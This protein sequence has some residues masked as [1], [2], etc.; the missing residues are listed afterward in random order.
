[1]HELSLVVDMLDQLSQM[2]KQHQLASISD[3]HV[4]VGEIS[5]VDAG[6]LRSTFD[7]H[8]PGTL[9]ADLRLHLNVIPWQVRCLDCGL[10]QVVRDWENQCQHCQSANTETI[11][12]KEFIIKRIEGETHV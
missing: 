7:L 1:M 12:G 4:E 11:A 2:K 6:F 3:V 5:G 8:I 9:W 10:E